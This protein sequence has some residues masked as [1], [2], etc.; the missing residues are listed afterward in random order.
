MAQSVERII[1]NVVLIVFV[2]FV[3][4]LILIVIFIRHLLFI[5]SCFRRYIKK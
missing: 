5:F 3:I 1:E 2:L 4:I